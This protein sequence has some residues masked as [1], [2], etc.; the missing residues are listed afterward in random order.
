MA[1]PYF[2]TKPDEKDASEVD[3]H[4]SWIKTEERKHTESDKIGPRQAAVV[5]DMRFGSRECIVRKSPLLE[6]VQVVGNIS[7]LRWHDQPGASRGTK[8]LDVCSGRPHMMQTDIL[9]KPENPTKSTTRCQC[10]LR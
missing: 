10:R 8:A 5:S 6:K 4:P 2:D 3:M 9:T 1:F 7:V